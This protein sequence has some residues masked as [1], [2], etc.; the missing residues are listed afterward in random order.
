MRAGTVEPGMSSPG[1]FI[2]SSNSL[3]RLLGRLAG[4]LRADPL[5]PLAFERIVVQSAGMKRWLTLELAKEL[6]IAASISMPYPRNAAAW[7]AR[8][9]IGSTEEDETDPFSRGPLTWRLMALLGEDLPGGEF[10]PIRAYLADNDARKRYQL[11]AKIAATFEEYQLYRTELLRDWDLEDPDAATFRHLGWQSKLWQRLCADLAGQQHLG[12]RFRRLISHINRLEGPA[13]ETEGMPRRLSVFGVSSLPPVFIDLLAALGRLIPVTVYRFSPT[14]STRTISEDMELEGNR[15]LNAMGRQGSEFLQ[16]LLEKGAVEKGASEETSR[17]NSV[18]TSGKASGEASKREGLWVFHGRLDGSGK[19]GKDGPSRGGSDEGDTRT[20]LQLIQDDILDDVNRGGKDALPLDPGDRSLSVHICHSPLREMEVLHDLLL[21][22]FD[23]MPDLVPG[24][25]LV[26]VPVIRD[27]APYIDAVFGVRHDAAPHIP[28]RIA[29]RGKSEEQPLSEGVLKVLAL[30]DVRLTATEVIDLLEIPS[31]R[32]KA[33]I[34]GDELPQIRHWVRETNIRWGVDGAFKQEVFGLPPFE[35]NTWRAGLDRLLM[36]MITGPRDDLVAGVLPLGT[37]T[38]NQ[39]DLLGR[40]DTWVTGLFERLTEM[41]TPRSLPG[42]AG[43]LADLLENFFAPRGDEEQ[44]LQIVRDELNRMRE[45]HALQLDIAVIRDHLGRA[46]D[47]EGRGVSFISGAV[48]FCALKPLRTIP[49]RVIAVA[50]LDDTSFPSKER[51]PTFDLMAARPRSGDRSVRKDQKQLFLETL[52]AATDRLIISYVGRSQK[53]NKERAASVVVEELLNVVDQSLSS[54]V[55]QS[56][57]SRVDQSL[58]SRVD[59]SLSSRVDQSLSSRV[60]QSL[61]S[62]VDQSLSLRGAERRSNL[63]SPRDIIT[64]LHPLQPFNAAYFDRRDDRLFSYS[65]QNCRAAEGVR[66][67][68]AASDPPAAIPFFATPVP[69]R[70]EDRERL[71]LTLDELIACWTHPCKFFCN[72][73][74]GIVLPREEAEL[75]DTEPL[76]MAGLEKYAFENRLAGERLRLAAGRGPG[77]PLPPPDLEREW[78]IL[79]ARG[80]LPPDKLG[81]AW[82]AQLGARVQQYVKKVGAPRILDPLTVELEGEVDGRPW[83][84]TGRIDNLTDLGRLQFR[85]ATLKPKDII[86][87]WFTH[88]ACNALLDELDEK[89]QELDD[90]RRTTRLIATD[91]EMTFGPIDEPNRILGVYLDGCRT[92]L[93]E[94]VP[95]FEKTSHAFAAQRQAIEN[96]KR[97]GKSTGSMASPWQKAFGQ[98]KGDQYRGDA[99]KGEREDPYIMLCYRGQDALEEQKDEFEQWAWSLWSGA[100]NSTVE[101]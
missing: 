57:S 46:L 81:R 41:R 39:L 67:A 33:A 96:K 78:R 35:A 28:Y 76:E 11:A 44:A 21:E 9:L 69:P 42:W 73:A 79:Q 1:F 25:V 88:L 36:G 37:A 101:L 2:E 77:E 89:G 53:D 97:E 6:G 30:A 71:G 64:T 66:T 19:A 13:D 22:A 43:L 4:V 23:T 90:H 34:R 61:S 54:R 60:D 26:L 58:S 80:D 68:R 59:Q 29:D 38:M 17:E 12:D 52:T 27:Y 31:V 75:E 18:I 40:F 95:L 7:L 82:H 45:A 83:K 14:R 15:L 92:M 55:D 98:W 56:L 20:A 8:K 5:P 87:A 49:F 51:P 47:E 99:A 65:L 86:R 74:L 93:R 10:A 85:C 63:S 16:L 100:L 91:Q 62:R 50:G 32:R 72:K 84:L 48:T 70:E 24:D 3:P 94:P